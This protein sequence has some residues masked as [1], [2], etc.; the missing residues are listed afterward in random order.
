MRA[1]RIAPAKVIAEQLSELNPEALTA[2]GFDDALVG[3]VY[4]KCME[5]I[6]LYDRA[7]CISILMKQ[8]MSRELAEEYFCFNVDDAWVGEG[9]PAFLVRP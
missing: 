3:I 1:L 2:D 6:A 5:P 8:G 4:R 9:T 7:K